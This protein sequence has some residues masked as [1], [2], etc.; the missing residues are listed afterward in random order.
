MSRPFAQD[1]RLME[2]QFLF[3]F[4]ATRAAAGVAMALLALGPVSFLILDDAG[5][6]IWAASVLG[7]L[8]VACGA[9]QRWWPE[10]RENGRP[11]MYCLCMLALYLALPLLSYFLIDDSDFAKSRVTRQF[12]LLG[13]PF[14]LLLLW[15]LR[16][17]LRMVL[18]LIAFNAAFFGIYAFVY[19]WLDPGRVEGSVHAVHFGNLSLF[20]GFASLGLFAVAGRRGWRILAVASMI[21]GGAAS[22]LAGARGGWLAAPLLFAVTL[23]MLTRVF[24]LGRHVVFGMI[25]LTLLV[26]AGL[27]HTDA[28]RQRIDKV[29]QN[30]E[31]LE[32]AES[33]WLDNSIGVR[34]L[35][36]EQAWLEIR[37]APLLGSGFSGY[38][39]RMQ[40]AVASGELPKD[41]LDFATEPHN[42]YLYQWLTRGA[43]GL[44]VF[45]LCL[46]G[47][48]WY[49]SDLLLRGN[50][51]QV[52]V[53]QVGLSLVAIIAVGGL[54]ITVIDQRAVIR[55]LGWIL[56][57]LLYC[58]WLC[59]KESAAG[60]IPEIA[61][62]KA[63]QVNP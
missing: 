41:M 38:R 15:W 14:V 26:V 46:A 39:D 36:W 62:T 13:T 17:G 57:L 53:A 2:P 16:P 27:W 48:A 11:V 20:L 60:Q 29:E 32:L 22:V 61:S 54:T 40:T 47:A 51:S 8:A 3:R 33:K 6:I 5:G 59:G 56:A 58:I 35:M 28:V 21:L 24:R 44:T 52:A 10:L 43:F 9:R 31:Q 34:I 19:A 45:L 63:S 23:I 4:L 42:E 49:F 37:E 30:L 25:V 1:N 7:G 55:F 18:A 50:S 12:L